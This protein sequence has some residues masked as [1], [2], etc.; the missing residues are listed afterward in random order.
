MSILKGAESLEVTDNSD[1][2]FDRL[3]A[4]I[5]Q[6]SELISLMKKR[7]DGLIKEVSI[8]IVNHSV[9]VCCVHMIC[10]DSNTKSP[11]NALYD[12]AI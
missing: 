12:D 6:Q 2:D 3:R 1:E 4:R 10:T 5:E 7:S 8:E 11:S 9:H